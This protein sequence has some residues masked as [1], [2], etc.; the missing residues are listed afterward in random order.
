MKFEHT[1]PV[2]RP[3]IITLESQEEVNNFYRAVT[4]AYDQSTRYSEVEK[5]ANDLLNL[6]RPIA[7]N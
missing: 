4:I 2:F 6:T 5:L 3:V 1:E 7:T